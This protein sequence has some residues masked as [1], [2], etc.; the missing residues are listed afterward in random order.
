MF[1]A[2]TGRHRFEGHGAS[3]ARF[4]GQLPA[5]A[6]VAVWLAGF[7]AII[8]TVPPRPVIVTQWANG[9]MMDS[10]DLFPDFARQFN[11]EDHK[12]QSG[13]PIEVRLTRANSGEIA[14]E[15]KSRVLYG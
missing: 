3:L 4:A 7:I 12:T 10:A 2:P 8:A 9:H 5:L 15:L 11:R 1:A 6:V 14:G 13:N